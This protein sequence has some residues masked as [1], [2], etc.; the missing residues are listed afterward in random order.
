M[1]LRLLDMLDNSFRAF[2]SESAVNG[3]AEYV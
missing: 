1:T 3:N 2:A